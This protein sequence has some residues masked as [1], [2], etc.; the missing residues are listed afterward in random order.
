MTAS[1]GP[2]RYFTVAE[3][4]TTDVVTVSTSTPIKE[5]ARVM[6]RSRIAAIPVV[7]VDGALVGIISETDFMGKRVNVEVVGELMTSPV[8]TAAPDDVVPAA[9]RTLLARNVKSLPVV[10]AGGRLVGIVSRADL[11]KVFLRSDEDIHRDVTASIAA[12][13]AEVEPPGMSVIVE[14]GIVTLTGTV[15]TPRDAELVV[16]AAVA[17]S[18]TVHVRSDGLTIQTEPAP[19]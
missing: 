5:A 3:V 13:S 4:M 12:T 2:T 14:D 1:G 9:A 18:G 16:T 17:V 8:A 10:D 7:G 15:S 6:T 19:S 11:L